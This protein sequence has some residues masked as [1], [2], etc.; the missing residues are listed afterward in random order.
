MRNSSS[1]VMPAICTLRERDLNRWFK[2]LVRFRGARSSCLSSQVTAVFQVNQPLNPEFQPEGELVVSS[3]P[4]PSR[5]A[6][7]PGGTTHI[8]GRIRAVETAVMNIAVENPPS[9]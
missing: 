4:S 1:Q 2:V 9:V 3:T 5:L 7:I 8:T 6:V